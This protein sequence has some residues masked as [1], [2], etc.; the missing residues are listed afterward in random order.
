MAGSFKAASRCAKESFRSFVWSEYAPL[1]PLL[2]AQWL[3]L[4]LGLNLGATWGMAVAGTVAR[5]IVGDAAIDY[6][7]FLELLPVT[8]SYVESATFIVL[9]AFALPVLVARVLARVKPPQGQAARARTG[10]AIL[11]TFLALLAAFLLT[12]AWQLF[13]SRG[14]HSLVAIFVRG[15]LESGVV[16]WMVSVGVGYAIMSLLLY[17]PVVAVSE[18]VGPGGALQRGVQEGLQR[19]WATYP[20]AL[21]LSLPALLVQLVVQIGGSLLATRTRPENI[22]YL[23]MLYVPVST[24]ATYF[25]WSMATRYFHTRTESV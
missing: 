24:V 9:G 25:V 20:Y 7:G 12:Y 1:L 15:G 3:F 22:A 21:L 6:P 10:G 17:V 8:F 4:I 18:D 16:T 13:A 23:L 11:P 19:F 2:V 14:L 5:W